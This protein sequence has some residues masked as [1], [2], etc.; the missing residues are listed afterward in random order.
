MA[1]TSTTEGRRGLRRAV[2]VGALA[3]ALA[4]CGVG[5]PRLAPIPANPASIDGDGSLSMSGSGGSGRARFSFVLLPPDRARIDVFDPLGRLAYFF[6]VSGDE[7]LLA[8]PSKKAFGRGGRDEVFARFLGFGLSPDELASLLTGRWTHAPAGPD[9]A[10]EADWILGRDAQG[11][12]ASAEK[13]GLRFEV[14]D[15][16][17]DSAAP[18]RI[19][20]EH[21]DS[22]GRLKINRLAFDRLPPGAADEAAL[23]KG[24]GERSWPEMEAL[25][26]DE[27]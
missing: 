22:R 23:L 25:L 9:A 16:F 6:L 15:F 12:V 24:Y 10:S 27:D 20:F 5:V 18:R 7:A 17:R 14:L 13:G 19:A 21:P 26:G 11:R 8:V 4:A 2:L 1:S 3:A